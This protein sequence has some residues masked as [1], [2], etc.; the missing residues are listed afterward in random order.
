MDKSL[1]E[2]V[3]HANDIVE[4]VQSYVP[5]KHVGSNWRG[6]CPFHNDTNP[7][8]YV[9][10]PKQIFKCFACGKAGNVFTFV[11]EYEKLTFIEALKK[12]AARVGISLLQYG[13]TKTVSTK[14]EQLL[15]I[16]ATAR[17]FFSQNLF[18]YGQ[19]ALNY[20]QERSFS[21]ETAK[22]LELGFSLNSEKALLSHLLKE[23]HAVSLLKESGLFGNYSGNL[24]DFFRGR[25]MF[26]IHNN[27]G[28]V[29]AF[30]GRVFEGDAKIAKYVNS[31]GTELYTK[32]KELYGLFKT[33]YEI[34]KAGTVLVSEGYFDFLRLYEN[35]FLNSVACLG[36]AMTEDQVYLLSRYSPKVYM[37]FDGDTAGI[38]NAVRGA[39]LCLGKGLEAHIVELPPKHDPDSFLLEKGAD[40][41]RERIAAAKPVLRF[42]AQ[43]ESKIPASDR[44]DQALDALRSLRDPIKRE[45]F[46]RDLAEAFGISTRA[47][48]S[49]L[50]RTSAVSKA[51]ETVAPAPV[52]EENFEE[53]QVLVLAL[54]D[55]DAF[56]LLAQTL[57][58]DYF[59]NR[60]YREL[61]K[62]LMAT[63]DADSIS[64]PATLLDNI[65]NKDLRDLLAEFLFS[66][67]PQ[68]EFGKA[69]DQI[70]LRKLQRDM[71]DL[72]R[73]IQAAPEDIRLLEEKRKLALTYRSLSRKVVRGL[74]I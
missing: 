9:S 67:P 48:F 30:G 23:G 58:P 53:R 73:R 36:T 22:T 62:H 15:V 19:N 4:V 74:L 52:L 25:L 7:S 66:E 68:V 39:L 27:I 35:G 43:M 45:L 16:Y 47:V 1:I 51:R 28:E 20:L 3:R 8:M 5:L 21:P 55:E 69:L 33:K 31:S 44:I 72:D 2:S 17:D 59:N 14:R 65:E 57:S 38:S 56:N 13:E 41:L 26:P 46:A 12:L 60:L 18:Q 71:R 61:F 11:Q 70:R 54:Q 34:S 37:L 50:R 6:I 24:V 63:A 64:E 32:G 29:I 49:K 10:Q 40:A 42:I